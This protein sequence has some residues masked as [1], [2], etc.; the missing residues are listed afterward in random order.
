MK[1]YVVVIVNDHEVFVG[2]VYT[3]REHAERQLA[4]VRK[5]WTAM[6]DPAQWEW[7][8]NGDTDE[9]SIMDG[10]EARLHEVGLADSHGNV[11]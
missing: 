9:L 8:D 4:L 10:P 1:G 6:Y 11:E 5:E 7:I 3:E 2:N